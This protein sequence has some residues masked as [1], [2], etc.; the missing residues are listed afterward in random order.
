MAALKICTYLKKEKVIQSFSHI[1]TKVACYST[2]RINRQ[3]SQQACYKSNRA[4]LVKMVGLSRLSRQSRAPVAVD[5]IYTVVQGFVYACYYFLK[6]I[7]CLIHSRV[8]FLWPVSTKTTLD[9][10][11][12]LRKQPVVLAGLELRIASQAV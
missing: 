8:C 11:S 1:H 7:A 6:L 12:C 10:V 2:A 4:N 5:T 3:E 9:N